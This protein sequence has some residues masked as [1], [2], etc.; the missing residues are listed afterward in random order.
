MKHTRS[1]TARVVAAKKTVDTSIPSYNLSNSQLMQFI[2]FDCNCKEKVK[3][4]HEDSK[5]ERE[6]KQCEKNIKTHNVIP[7]GKAC[8][9]REIVANS[10]G[11]STAYG[12]A[13]LFTSPESTR[14]SGGLFAN[15]CFMDL[16]YPVWL[17]CYA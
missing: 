13:Q 10:D 12:S 9:K 8:I 15:I 5:I 7:K 3:Q 16:M 4:T 6:T 11:G 14:G 1:K 17:R 2:K